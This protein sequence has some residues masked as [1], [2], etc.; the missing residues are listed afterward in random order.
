MLNAP[1]RECEGGSALHYAAQNGLLAA[2]HMLNVAGIELDM[3]DKEQNSP[4]LLAIL[5]LKNNV[6]RY[7]IKVGANITL[8]V[9]KLFQSKNIT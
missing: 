6:V 2:V 3:L 9:R 8:K 4:L 1:L 7:L 5:A